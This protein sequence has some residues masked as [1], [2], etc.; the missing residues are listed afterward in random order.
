MNLLSL[1]P[2]PPGWQLYLAGIAVAASFGGG[3]YVC[4]VFQ[5]AQVVT[6]VKKEIQTVYK[7]QIVTQTV[8][9]KTQTAQAATQVRY[10]TIKEQVPVYVKDYNPYVSNSF[11]RLHDA[12]ATDTL[13]ATPGDPDDAP[14][15]IKT[16]QALD[17]IVDNYDTCHLISERLTGLQE[18]VAKQAQ[19]AGAPKQ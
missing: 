15:A 6:Q 10:V 9:A 13:P 4:S 3:W 5:R 11:I 16:D 1:L 17:T 14:S 7:Q 18:W 12:A 8:E 2:L 19:L